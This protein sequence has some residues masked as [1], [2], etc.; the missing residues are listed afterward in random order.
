VTIAVEVA[1]GDVDSPRYIAP[2]IALVKAAITDVDKD[3]Y[4]RAKSSRN[5]NDV[6]KTILEEFSRKRYP[7][8]RTLQT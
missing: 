4:F 3:G 7:R 8:T 1:N 5:S 2:M 6:L